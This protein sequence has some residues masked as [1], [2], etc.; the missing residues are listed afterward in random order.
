MLV[1]SPVPSATW[2]PPP[3]SM[4]WIFVENPCRAA[5]EVDQEVLEGGD[6][7]SVR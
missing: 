5:V 3:W 2:I 7:F 4:P 6:R 1:K